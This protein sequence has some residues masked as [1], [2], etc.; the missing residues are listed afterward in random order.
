MRVASL[1]TGILSLVCA[2]VPL[3]GLA[4]GIV[5]VCCARASKSG[6]KMEGIAVGGLVCGIIGLCIG[7]IS[8]LVTGCSLIAFG[9]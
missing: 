5:A 2:F 6:E 1:V 3:L 7:G 4:L 8:S 9:V